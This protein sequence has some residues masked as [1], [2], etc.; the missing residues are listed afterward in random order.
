MEQ[1]LRQI[2]FFSIEKKRL[3]ESDA[4][5]AEDITA[6]VKSKSGLVFDAGCGEGIFTNVAT[7]ANNDVY[8]IGGDLSKFALLRAKIRLSGENVDLLMCD[9]EKLPFRNDLF[10]CVISINMLHHLPSLNP[11]S[12]IHRVAKNGCPFLI[13]DHAYLN[14]PLFFTFFK[15]ATYLPSVFLK[16]R[17]DVGVQHETPSVLMYSFNHLMETL[18]SSSFR[19]IRVKRDILFFTPMVSVLRAFSQT[20][21]LPFE[22]FLNGQ[23][24]QIFSELDKKL[25][26]YLCR[27]CYEFVIYC[28][29]EKNNL[30][31]ISFL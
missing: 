5:I 27:F 19:S 28:V 20:F 18:E 1:K 14:N 2:E 10:D 31:N 4:R 11:I 26:K 24:I 8:V 9:V 22:G 30:V 23:S 13:C 12:E 3:T 7:K 16:F 15:I 17:E 21:K 29:N 25:K 6:I